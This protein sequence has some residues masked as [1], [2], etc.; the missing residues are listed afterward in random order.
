M[1]DGEIWRTRLGPAVIWVLL[2]EAPQS[3]I[4]SLCPELLMNESQKLNWTGQV[5]GD[6]KI[7]Y[8]INWTGHILGPWSLWVPWAL[9]VGSATKRL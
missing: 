7:N 5:L 4:I 9:V 2:N 6:I 3:K 8:H 1:K